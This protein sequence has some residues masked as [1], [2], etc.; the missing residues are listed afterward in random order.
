MHGAAVDD[1]EKEKT[2]AVKNVFI[3]TEYRQSEELYSLLTI[4]SRTK[5]ETLINPIEVDL[6]PC[7]KKCYLEKSKTL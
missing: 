1:K 4:L 2:L 3:R 7:P 5:Y 6:T